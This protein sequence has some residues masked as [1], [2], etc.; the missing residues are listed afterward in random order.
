MAENGDLYQIVDVQTL[1]GQTCLNVFFYKRT[2][3][4][5]VGDPAEEVA[6]TYDSSMLPAILA[7]QG[8]SVLHTEIRVQ[9]LFDPSDQFTKVISEA[10]T[11]SGTHP[12]NP[13]DSFG[14]RLQQDNG[15][16]RNGAKRFAGMLDESSAA[17]I[18]DDSTFITALLALGVQLVTGLDIGIVSGA[19]VPVIVKRILESGVYRLPANS[20][21]AVYG[22]VTEALYNADVTSQV[23][24]KIGRGE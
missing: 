14:F 22:N 9:N 11:F 2:I 23:S 1:D 12:A 20:G 8:T 21:E 15:T 19:L 5:L 10:G 13:F 7:C 16:V 18:I 24:R 4:V 17:G 6:D 3:S